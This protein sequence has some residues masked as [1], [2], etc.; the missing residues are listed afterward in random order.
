M[1]LAAKSPKIF[2]KHKRYFFVSETIDYLNWYIFVALTNKKTILSNLKKLTGY[3]ASGV[4]IVS[5]VSSNP[6]I[7]PLPK[8]TISLFLLSICKDE[9]ISARKMTA[10]FP[11]YGQ[12][13]EILNRNRI[14]CR[15]RYIHIYL[16]QNF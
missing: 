14:Q 4:N 9:L 10:F 16:A 3:G 8:I 12:V 2:P 1:L 5:V 7:G 13:I 11:Y 15:N 6:C